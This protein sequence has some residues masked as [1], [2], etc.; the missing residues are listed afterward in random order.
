MASL[1]NIFEIADYEDIKQSLPINGASPVITTN[2]IDFSQPGANLYGK[3]DRRNEAIVPKVSNNNLLTVDGSQ[4]LGMIS[5]EANTQVFDFVADAYND[6]IDY[7]QSVR[8]RAG[9]YSPDSYEDEDGN[10]RQTFLMN[11][12]PSGGYINPKALHSEHLDIIYDHFVKV[13]LGK[14]SRHKQ[15]NDHK[16]FIKMFVNYVFSDLFT[17]IASINLSSHIK[18]S[19]I[20]IECTGLVVKVAAPVVEDQVNNNQYFW[21]DPNFSLYV[22]TAHKFGF[23]VDKDRPW[24]LVA[25]LGSRIMDSYLRARGSF[26]IKDTS[27]SGKTHPGGLGHIH[28]YEIDSRGDGR[29]IS[30]SAGPD[31]THTIKNYCVK[32]ALKELPHPHDLPTQDV[33]T[34]YYERAQLNELKELITLLHRMYSSYIN[35]NPQNVVNFFE[36]GKLVKKSTFRKNVSEQEFS[37][38]LSEK[39][40]I[41]FYFDL[42]INEEKLFLKR[43]KYLKILRNAQEKVLSSTKQEAVE[44]INE[45]INKR[46][47]YLVQGPNVNKYYHNLPG[48]NTLKKLAEYF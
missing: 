30:T 31:H 24:M 25:N 1:I 32:Y 40:W 8:F 29:T 3:V 9:E 43:S 14:K 11:L 27:E 42:K 2:V 7:L 41:R 20:P 44:Y 16:D 39:N 48:P 34:K 22:S 36:A 45:E 23:Y 38:A 33:F 10:T 17:N 15:I 46:L 37:L 47:F 6:M 13:Y 19:L 28:E 18:K 21:R 35:Q 26:L 5:V 12:S 4:A